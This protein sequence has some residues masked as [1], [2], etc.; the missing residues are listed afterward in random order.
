[1]GYEQHIFRTKE[2]KQINHDEFEVLAK[3]DESLIYLEGDEHTIQ[4][5]GHPLG[6]IEGQVPLLTFSEGR[7]ST[8]HPDEFVTQKMFE[9]AQRM[10]AS[11]GDDEGVFDDDHRQEIKE[12][13]KGILERSKRQSEKPKWKFW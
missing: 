10:N 8:T 5:T 3:E 9:I 4:W 11:L 6:G 13:C 7:I 1:M 12:S 2:N